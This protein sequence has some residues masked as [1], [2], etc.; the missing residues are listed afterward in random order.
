[1]VRRTL[2]CALIVLGI[3][4]AGASWLRWAAAERAMRT[5]GSLPA[6][7]LSVT[8]AGVL[9]ACALVVLVI[10]LVTL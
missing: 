10:V 3:I 1:M 9:S 4:C 5:R 6:S 2:A 7:W 8:L